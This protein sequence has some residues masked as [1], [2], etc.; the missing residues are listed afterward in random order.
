M[1]NSRDFSLQ[2][3]YRASAAASKFFLTD[4]FVKLFADCIRLFY[5]IAG[6][7]TICVCFYLFLLC[8]FSLFECLA[9]LALSWSLG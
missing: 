2:K 4:I 8:V 3:R 7:I 1:S 9:W 5:F 6:F